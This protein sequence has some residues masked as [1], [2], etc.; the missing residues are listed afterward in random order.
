MPTRFPL[1]A[2]VIKTNGCDENEG[3]YVSLSATAKAPNNQPIPCGPTAQ[4]SLAFA[5]PSVPSR[6]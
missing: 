6:V 3:I 1:L 2:L 5:R 4:N